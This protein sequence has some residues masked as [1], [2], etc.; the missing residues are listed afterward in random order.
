MSEPNG[1]SQALALF[2]PIYKDGYKFVA[3]AAAAT[4]VA[5]LFSG[6]L[7]LACVFA[8]LALVFFFRDPQRVV[9]VRD[10]LVVAPAD[11]TV[12]GI[13]NA[14]PPPELGLGSEPQSRVSI[15][16]SVFDVHVIRA[17]VS[18]RA[19]HFLLPARPAPQCGGARSARGE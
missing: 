15:F 14:V 8:T 3:I 17:P 12:I 5:F 19:W 9:P 16:L 11:G 10:G 6:T 1:L 7:G 18:G 13:G 2:S 4:I